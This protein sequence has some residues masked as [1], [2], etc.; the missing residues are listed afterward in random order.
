MATYFIS[1]AASLELGKKKKQRHLQAAGKAHGI[2]DYEPKG[3]QGKNI[4]AMA[5][6]IRQFLHTMSSECKITIKPFGIGQNMQ[7]MYGYIQKD[8]GSATYAF[9]AFNVDADELEKCRE[10]YDQQATSYEDGKIMITRGR[11]ATLIYAFWATQL[12]PLPVSEDVMLVLMVRAKSHAFGQQF[13]IPTSGQPISMHRWK[14]FMRHAFSPEKVTFHDIKLIVYN[15]PYQFHQKIET[16]FADWILPYDFEC[17]DIDLTLQVY[18]N[19]FGTKPLQ[20]RLRRGA[21]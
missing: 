4:L 16:V 15:K 8:Y 14:A 5:A 6:L 2:N 19:L 10:L 11:F 9:K 17:T 12:R 7:L 18:S 1:G 20:R 21:L 3:R 13:V